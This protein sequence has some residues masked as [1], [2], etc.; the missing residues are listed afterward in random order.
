MKDH[1]PP[2]PP[3]KKSIKY[4]DNKGVVLAEG[5]FTLKYEEYPL[6]FK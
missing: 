6:G 4:G 2:P 3:K 1:P 5:S